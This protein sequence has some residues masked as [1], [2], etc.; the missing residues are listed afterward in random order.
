MLTYERSFLR[1]FSKLHII[2]K[3]IGRVNVI[4]LN[5]LFKYDAIIIPILACSNS[6]SE[7]SDNFEIAFSSSSIICEKLGRKLHQD[8]TIL[9]ILFI[10]FALESILSKYILATVK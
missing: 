8:H 7:L 2:E 6:G 5:L 1:Q 10:V 3:S 4:K 9:L